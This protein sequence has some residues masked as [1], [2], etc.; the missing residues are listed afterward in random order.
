MSFQ[1]I[2]KKRFSY[3]LCL[4]L[5]LMEL[6]GSDYNAVGSAGI[7]PVVP[8]QQTSIGQFLLAERRRRT[9]EYFRR[10]NQQGELLA[11]C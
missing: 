9:M 6:C 2:E 1:C 3:K 4:F 8:D 7:G 11:A 10:K 5:G